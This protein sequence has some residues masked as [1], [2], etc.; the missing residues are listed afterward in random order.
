MFLKSKLRYVDLLPPPEI[1]IDV[2]THYIR[3]NVV[4]VSANN[5]MLSVRN[6]IK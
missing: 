5:A 2:N 1:I 3:E 4:N 6:V